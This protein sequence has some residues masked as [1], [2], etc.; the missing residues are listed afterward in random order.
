[1]T[2]PPAA[3]LHHGA[4]SFYQ[5]WQQLNDWLVLHREFWQP[6]PFMTPEPAWAKVYPQLTAMLAELTDAECQH[7][8]DAPIELA[9]RASR[10]LPSLEA[11]ADLVQLPELLPSAEKALEATLPE[12]RATDMPGRKRLQSGAFAAALTPLEHSALDWC[13]GKGHLSRT[14]APFCP[15]EIQGLEWNPELVRD[16]NRLA[17][18]FGDR[19]SIGCQDVMAAELA[20]PGNHHGVALHACGDLHRQLLKRGSEAGLPRLSIS[21]CCYH[22]T[23]QTIYR[24]L[25]RRASGYQKV[26][27]PGRNDLRLAVQETVTAPARVREQTR[28]ISQWRLGFDGLQRFL[29]GHDEYLPVPSHPARLLNEGFP[30]FCH[31]AAAKKHLELPNSLDFDHWLAFGERR[32]AEVRRHELVRHLFRRPL[33]LWMVLD[34]AIYLEE[35]G[36]RVRLGQFCDRALTPRNLLLDA[37]RVSDTLPVQHSHP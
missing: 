36:Y 9:A 25:S 10:W 8:D 26:L 23:D 37:V 22:L 27:Q 24:P 29:R 5:R 30:A 4:E 35:Q 3:S 1:M 18:H 32:L 16:G 17:Q 14:L 31:W 15:G 13:C 21:P 19:V 12:I 7:L 20:L 11:Y 6:A 33:E 34:Y 2:L 28:R